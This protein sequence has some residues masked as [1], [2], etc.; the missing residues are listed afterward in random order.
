[1]TKKIQW[2]ILGLGKIAHKFAHDL[3]L[4]SS[5][6]L[7]AVAS[8]SVERAAAF[9]QEHK[10][11]VA[12]GNYSSLFNDESVEVIYIASVHTDHH[13]HSCAALK[14]GK[15]VLCEKPLGINAKEVKEMIALA[16]SKRLFFMEALWSRFNPAL[17]ALKKSVE[18]GKIGDL[19]HIQASFSMSRLQDDPNGRILNTA[20]GGGS[21]LDIGIYPVF[22][23]YLFLGLPDE[24]LAKTHFN[25]QGTEIQTSIIFHYSQA[26]AQLYSSLAHPLK[27]EAKLF[28]T[29]GEVILHPT[30]HETEAYTRIIDAHE[31]TE[32]HPKE[33]L[34]YVH[35]IEEVHQCLNANKTE[36]KLWSHK[37][38]L[39]LISLLDEIR[40][41]TGIQFPQEA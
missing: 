13:S 15:A 25:E 3:A 39:N 27:M 22:L 21:L 41:Q 6:E 14:A 30:W 1:M 18:Q 40:K 29:K 11:N 23:A 17:K 26:Q 38:S 16:Q 20:M 33:G 2:G 8:S 32:T 4:V 36:S 19:R 28:G 31:T 10:A 24:I 34:G 35:E 5:A 7:Y 12:Y 37:D 9:A